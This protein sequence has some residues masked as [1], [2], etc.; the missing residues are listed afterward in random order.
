MRIQTLKWAIAPALLLMTACASMSSMQTGEVLEDGKT[1]WTVGGG[2]YNSKAF[3][4]AVEKDENN[5]LE[6]V[7]LPY[8]EASYRMGL[9]NKFD[10]GAKLT[11]IGTMVADGKYQFYDGEAFDASIGLGLGYMSIETESNDV[12]SKTTI[13]DVMVPA[14]LSY[15][16]TETITPY[17]SPRYILRNISGEGD[18]GSASLIGATAGLKAGN[19]WGGYFEYGYQKSLKNDFSA[20]QV[21]VALFFTN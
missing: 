6:D 21:N 14:Y 10:V 4:T 5:V 12:K 2:T 8:L 13:V 15:K 1:Q 18:S 19:E 9:G 20:G 17:I 11:L 16:A 3:S 7:N